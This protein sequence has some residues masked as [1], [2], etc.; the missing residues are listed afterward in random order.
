[1]QLRILHARRVCEEVYHVEIAVR[2]TCLAH[3]LDVCLVKHH[4]G[5]F[6]KGEE[7]LRA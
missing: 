7:N 1:M 4:F 5:F 6:W 3:C 2:L